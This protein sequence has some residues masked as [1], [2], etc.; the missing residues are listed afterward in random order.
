MSRQ[1]NGDR[2]WEG[3]LAGVG[4]KDEESRAGGAGEDI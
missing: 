4:S 1:I 3:C 2:P